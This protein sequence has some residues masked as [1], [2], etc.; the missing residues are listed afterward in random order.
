MLCLHLARLSGRQFVFMAN[1]EIFT[2]WHG[3]AGWW[4]QRLGCFSVE[5]GGNNAEAIRY[6]TEAVKNISEP[7]IVFPEGE[8]HYLNDLVQP[9]KTGAVNI[10]MRAV[11]EM[12]DKRPDWTVYMVPVAL[13]YRYRKPIGSILDK[14]IRKMERHLSRKIRTS[15]IRTRLALILAEVLHRQE[16]LHNLQ[17]GSAKLSELNERV[18]HVH[19]AILTQLEQKYSQ[20]ADVLAA[21]I[22]EGV[23]QLSSKLRSLL[24][25]TRT[26][27]RRKDLF[28][29]LNTLKQISHMQSLQPDYVEVDPSQERLAEMVLKL[30]REVYKVKRVHQLAKRDIFVRVGEWIDLREFL[31][32]YLEDAHKARHSIAEQLRDSI[33]GLIDAMTDATVSDDCKQA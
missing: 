4:L 15:E 30:E 16:V 12:Q 8:I 20:E 18:K 10:G 17:S 14:R 27:L 3:I 2:E 19:R 26:A 13:K 7:L 23:W 28:Q 22:A 25:K 31:P 5:R 33:Q 21:N 29:D 32:A 11:T 9:F 6:A 24:R 1:S